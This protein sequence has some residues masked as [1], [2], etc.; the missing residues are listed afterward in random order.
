[1]PVHQQAEVGGLQRP[2]PL[3]FTHPPSPQQQIQHQGRHPITHPVLQLA[4]AGERLCGGA[5]APQPEQL[6]GLLSRRQDQ[7]LSPLRAG[8]LKGRH[9]QLRARQ[10][11]GHQ[12]VERLQQ[13]RR[14]A[15]V[16]REPVTGR[17]CPAGRA[18]GVEIASPETVDGLLGISHQHQQVPGLGSS[19]CEGPVQDPPLQGIG[20]L[21]L[22]DQR[23]PVA[24]GE[25][26]DQ[27]RPLA[28]VATGIEANEQVAVAHAPSPLPPPRQLRPGPVAEMAEHRLGRTVHQG[29]RRFQQARAGAASAADPPALPPP[30]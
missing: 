3:P 17:G 5:I 28:A 2:A 14:G 23:C 29:R 21:E 10:A 24:L 27:A 1:M 22:I 19:G 11:R 9:R 25:G 7:G 6:Q 15:E 4:A 30:G 8:G 26:L 16:A 18:V 20:V 13:G 12:T